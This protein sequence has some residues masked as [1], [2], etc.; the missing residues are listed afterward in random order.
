MP[1]AASSVKP[2]VLK[3]GRFISQMQNVSAESGEGPDST[4]IDAVEYCEVPI[5][6]GLPPDNPIPGANGARCSRFAGALTVA[7]IALKL[8]VIP[9]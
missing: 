2:E 9:Y 4:L 1:T 6:R 3:S 8:S 7:L 5:R